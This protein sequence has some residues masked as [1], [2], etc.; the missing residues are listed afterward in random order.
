MLQIAFGFLKFETL[1]PTKR[2]KPTIYGQHRTRDKFGRITTQKMDSTVQF[3]Y[4]SKATHWGVFDD[5]FSSL[6]ICA[7]VIGQQGFI[8]FANKKPGGYRIDPDPFAKF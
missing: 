8:L 1:N 2:T 6:R 5:I 4:V 7:V 3:G